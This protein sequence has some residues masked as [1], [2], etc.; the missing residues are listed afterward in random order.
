MWLHETLALPVGELLSNCQDN[1]FSQVKIARREFS[2]FHD[3]FHINQALLQ[4]VALDRR[5]AS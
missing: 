4:A 2:Q 3:E 5:L 1:I